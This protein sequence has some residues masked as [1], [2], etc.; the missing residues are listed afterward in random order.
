MDYVLTDQGR[1]FLRD[2]LTECNKHSLSWYQLW[3]K[4]SSEAAPAREALDLDPA[5]MEDADSTAKL[6]G[7]YAIVQMLESIAT[8]EEDST[9]GMELIAN[10]DLLTPEIVD[11]AAATFGLTGDALRSMFATDLSG[12]L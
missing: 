7:A 4:D 5:E 12:R 8:G 2:A 6:F 3:S 9:L 11:A 1:T 10:I